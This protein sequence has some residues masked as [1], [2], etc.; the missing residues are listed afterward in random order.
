MKQAAIWLLSKCAVESFFDLRPH[1]F[2]Q[3]P[4][5]PPAA[6][7]SAHYAC[8]ETYNCVTFRQ[9]RFIRGVYFRPA[10]CRK[11]INFGFRR[12][13]VRLVIDEDAQRSFVGSAIFAGGLIAFQERHVALNISRQVGADA[14]L[15][16]SFVCAE[17]EE[18]AAER[19]TSSERA[20][21]KERAVP[22]VRAT[23]QEREI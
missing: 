14:N 7:E 11:T 9:N 3:R 13:F 6:E 18:R 15:A 21:S 17:I 10:C 23:N 22:S 2:C 20:S 16:D 4:S 1:V 12:I 5:A 19:A 8:S